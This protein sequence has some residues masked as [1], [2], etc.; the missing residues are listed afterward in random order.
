[1]LPEGAEVVE[2]IKITTEPSLECAA[3]HLAAYSWAATQIATDLDMRGLSYPPCILDIACGSGY[4]SVLLG[5]LPALVTGVD[6]DEDTIREALKGPR[7]ENK[8]GAVSYMSAD[9]LGFLSRTRSGCFD[10][11][12]SFQTLEHMEDMT[13]MVHELVRVSKY[14]VLLA[15]PYMEQEETGSEFHYHF[16]LDETSLMRRLPEDAIAAKVAFQYEQ[17]LC[18]FTTR[19]ETLRGFG[20]ASVFLF[21]TKTTK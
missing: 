10:Y 12:V 6:V 3:L 21:V 15:V 7:P 13:P 17:P 4:G 2:R 20:I 5:S 8:Q 14:G 11:A 9:A 16:N 1:M 19:K 18:G